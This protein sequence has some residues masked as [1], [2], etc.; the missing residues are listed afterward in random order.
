MPL[1][2]VFVGAGLPRPRDSRSRVAPLQSS[3]AIG[4]LCHFERSEESRFDRWQVPP[5][6]RPGYRN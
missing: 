3:A 4:L 2:F 5:S 1:S 6:S